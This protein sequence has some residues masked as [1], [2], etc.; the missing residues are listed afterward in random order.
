MS[1]FKVYLKMFLILYPFTVI[2]NFL[3]DKVLP[4]Y[5]KS[6][7]DNFVDSLFLAIFLTFIMVSFNFI[8][9]RKNGLKNFTDENLSPKQKRV[10]D[11]KLN[12]DDVL[13][14]LKEDTYFKKFKFE[15]KGDLIV[16]KTFSNTFSYGEIIKIA[17]ID[18]HD[19]MHQYIISSEPKNKINLLDGGVNYTNVTKIQALL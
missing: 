2:S 6:I 14:K 13:T 9:A 17:P 1:K 18:S 11:S 19:N 10:V 12:R 16:I 8:E 7:I 3:M 15:L 4:R 5:D